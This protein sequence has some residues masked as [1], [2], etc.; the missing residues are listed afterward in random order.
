MCSSIHLSSVSSSSGV[1]AVAPSTPKPPARLT[2]AMTS[3]Q[4]VNAN[5]GKSM[6]NILQTGVFIMHLLRG[7]VFLRGCD[8][9][10]VSGH[11]G[12]VRGDQLLTD[13]RRPMVGLIGPQ[14]AQIWRHLMTE[15]AGVFRGDILRDISHVRRRD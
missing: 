8:S 4:C 3:R 11:L 7:E 15:Q 2:A 14:I 1:N 10:S 5:N 6:P 13:L 12:R 9:L